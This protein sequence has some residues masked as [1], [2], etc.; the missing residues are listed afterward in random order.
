MTY[1]VM[2]HSSGFVKLGE[3]GSTANVHFA[4]RVKETAQSFRYLIP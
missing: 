4:S 1:S 2:D 3:I